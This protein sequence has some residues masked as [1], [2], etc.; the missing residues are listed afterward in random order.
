MRKYA[1]IIGIVLGVLCIFLLVGAYWAIR[2]YYKPQ[3]TPLSLITATATK[4]KPTDVSPAN[5]TSTK[6]A[7]ATETVTPTAVTQV[8]GQ[9]GSWM[10]L[11]LG[12]TIHLDPAPAQMI[13]L[14][15]VDF[16][17]Q[18]AT[19][20]SLPPDLV[21][22]TPGLVQ[23]YKIQNSRLQDIFTALV[24][25]NGE[26]SLTSYKATQATAQVILDNFGI[27]PNHYITLKENFVEEIIDTLGGIEVILPQDFTMPNYSTYKGTLIKA[28]KT[29][30]NGEMVHA[31]TTYRESTID[32]FTRLAHQ[33]VVLEGLRKKMLDPAAYIKIPKLYALYKENI[34]TDL[35]LEQIAA[36]SCLTRLIKPENITVVTPTLDQITVNQDGSMYMKNPA[37][38]VK[39]IQTLFEVP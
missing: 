23:E 27:A 19:I 16:D 28:G 13:R 20:Y 15:K 35:S 8:C 18:I 11:F 37:N 5:P 31:Y 39:Q 9:N 4:L 38:L 24:I 25:A 7:A 10:I 33:N 36:L 21:L 14:V 17:R 1:I 3:A 30:F 26:S 2:E 29:T 12:R 32:E 22:E 34:V 6:T